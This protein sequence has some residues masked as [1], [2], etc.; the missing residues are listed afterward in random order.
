MLREKKTVR[1]SCAQQYF[2]LR[3]TCSEI[4]ISIY[5]CDL[6]FLLVALECYN[7]IPILVHHK[8]VFE[9]V[10]VYKS[11]LVNNE[12]NSIS[13]LQDYHFRRSIYS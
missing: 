9:L 8:H 6:I 1:M 3:M 2:V 5:L 12:S 11:S 7:I 13:R 4:Y 10:N